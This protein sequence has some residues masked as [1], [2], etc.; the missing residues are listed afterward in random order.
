M[1]IKTHTDGQVRFET[2]QQVI[3]ALQQ[4]SN[5]ITIIKTSLLLMEG[6]V[7]QETRK[8]LIR[9]VT[10]EGE[11]RFAGDKNFTIYF[12]E[13]PFKEALGLARNA[14]PLVSG[15]WKKTPQCPQCTSLLV[16][17]KRLTER[18]GDQL[19]TLYKCGKCQSPFYFQTKTPT[20]SLGAAKAA[21]KPKETATK[22]KSTTAK[23]K[24]TTT[25]TT[26]TKPESTATKAKPKAT[27]TKVKATAKPESTAT[28][29][30]TATKTKP[31]AAANK[32][33]ATKAKP[34]ATTT[35]TKATAK[36]K[37]TTAKT[38]T[39]TK[40]RS[41]AKATITKTKSTAKPTDKTES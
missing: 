18:A 25:K 9:Y 8:L 28:T 29:K 12:F 20:P 3:T 13:K 24:A 39:A 17:K 1:A 16:E 27:T 2:I 15:R 21:T 5:F 38:K 22:P 19:I 37:A 14:F 26:A 6:K 36:P 4:S 35:K 33:T 41:T 10:P 30:T 31:K 34:K 40:K 23:P 7:D 32:A 11:V